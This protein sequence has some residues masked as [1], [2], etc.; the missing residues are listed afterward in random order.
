MTA[1]VSSQLD[2]PLAQ[3]GESIYDSWKAGLLMMAGEN[4]GEQGEFNKINRCAAQECP[5]H[6]PFLAIMAI[7][8]IGSG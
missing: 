3:T 5:G 7:P 6:S 4:D 8:G 2:I 1:T